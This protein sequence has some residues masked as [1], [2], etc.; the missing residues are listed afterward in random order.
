[1][2]IFRR[3]QKCRRAAAFAAYIESL[4]IEVYVS[5]DSS[6]F[7][8]IFCIAHP[9]ATINADRPT[10]ACNVDSSPNANR[11]YSQKLRSCPKSCKSKHWLFPQAKMQF[12]S[13]FFTS[14]NT[15]NF[16]RKKNTCRS[17]RVLNARARKIEKKNLERKKHSKI[18]QKLLSEKN[19]KITWFSINR[20]KFSGKPPPCLFV[21]SNNIRWNVRMVYRVH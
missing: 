11:G 1:M 12:L 21:R 10:N 4:P 18:L 15:S 5:R 14:K 8:F 2:A 3:G 16:F 20:P 7:H 6:E 13:T 9:N 17:R 19:E